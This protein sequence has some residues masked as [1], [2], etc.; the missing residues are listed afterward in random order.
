MVL[1][2]QQVLNRA[3]D[4]CSDSALIALNHLICDGAAPL[5]GYINK[6]TAIGIIDVQLPSTFYSWVRL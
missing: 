1:L 4:K 5:S 2:E 3:C 6:K